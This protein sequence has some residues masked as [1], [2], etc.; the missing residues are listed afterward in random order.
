[1]GNRWVYLVVDIA[2]Y[3]LQPL[4]FGVKTVEFKI[5]SE[6]DILNRALSGL[7]E[8]KELLRLKSVDWLLPMSKALIYA[9]SLFGTSHG[10]VM[11]EV[12]AHNDDASRS[13]SLG[14]FAVEHGEVIPAILPS[15]ATQMIL[16]GEITAKGIVPLPDWL[17][18]QRFV[19]ELTKRQVNISMK[20]DGSWH[21]YETA[22]LPP[23]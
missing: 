14:V 2:D 23:S 20:V 21:P 15:V 4:Y 9:A 18:S 6:L 16:R 11:V 17:P 8:F 3:F 5:G 10:G 22:R 19:D 1:M 12:S 7:R 13:I